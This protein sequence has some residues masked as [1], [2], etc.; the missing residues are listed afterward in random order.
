MSEALICIRFPRASCI[1]DEPPNHGLLMQKRRLDLQYHP[2][3]TEIVCNGFALCSA[4]FL[5]AFLF[6]KGASC[7]LSTET[8]IIFGRTI[9]S[10]GSFAWSKTHVSDK[11]WCSKGSKATQGG[12]KVTL[13]SS[14][15]TW[16]LCRIAKVAYWAPWPCWGIRNWFCCLGRR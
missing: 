13:L 14:A 4:Q 12:S 15:A 11:E 3:W 5:Y 8:Q 9:R 2:C 10:L 1:G 16:Q 6:L 7:P